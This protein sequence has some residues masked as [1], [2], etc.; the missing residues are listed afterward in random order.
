MRALLR[1]RIDA[2]ETV[3]IIQIVALVAMATTAAGASNVSH[4]Q[5][6]LD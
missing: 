5:T 6:E 3:N 2:N 1:A 4:A